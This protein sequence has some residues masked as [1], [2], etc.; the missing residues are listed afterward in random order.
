M[1]PQYDPMFRRILGLCP[2]AVLVFLSTGCALFNQ[3]ATARELSVR[4]LAERESICS[5]SSQAQEGS[6]IPLKHL[7]ASGAHYLHLG[8]LERGT[9][10]NDRDAPELL[11]IAEKCFNAARGLSPKRYEALLGLGIIYLARFRSKGLQSGFGS[12]AISGNFLREAY[13]AR[14]GAYE[15]LYYLAELKYYE[16]EPKAASALL[17]ILTDARV[18]LG[19]AYALKAEIAR[20]EGD[21]EAMKA[22]RLKALELGDPLVTVIY[23]GSFKH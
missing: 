21:Q 12:A 6:A 17:Q 19:P 3:V 15:P 18:K 7:L 16:G 10:A 8:L 20:D 14:G 4:V 11:A 13:L 23:A 9:D 22:Y 2:P 5:V 1:T